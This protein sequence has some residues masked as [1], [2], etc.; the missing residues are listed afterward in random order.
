MAKYKTVGNKVYIK[1]S[2][3]WFWE[4]A[5]TMDEQGNITHW[6][7]RKTG[8][9][10][11]RTIFKALTRKWRPDCYRDLMGGSVYAERGCNTCPDEDG[12]SELTKENGKCEK[13]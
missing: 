4:E 5:A 8:S 6:N 7:D 1:R 9:F 11:V 3:F 2:W 12:C 13:K 10:Y